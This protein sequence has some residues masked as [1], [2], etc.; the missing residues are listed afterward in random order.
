MPRDAYS[1]GDSTLIV[2]WE[3]GSEIVPE[4]GSVKQEKHLEEDPPHVFLIF[5]S[6]NEEMNGE[7]HCFS[8]N[9]HSS[10]ID[11]VHIIGKLHVTYSLNKNT[12][13]SLLFP[14]KASSFIVLE[15]VCRRSLCRLI[16][17]KTQR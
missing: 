12:S 5:T 7:Y 11:S 3:F 15:A 10:D 4:T 13:A 17:E 9:T 6:F 1:E 14:W 8:N 16:K 2:R